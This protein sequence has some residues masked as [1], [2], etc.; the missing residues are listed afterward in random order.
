MGR[1]NCSECDHLVSDTASACPSCG[2][3]T[4]VGTRRRNG[5]VHVGSGILVVIVANALSNILGAVGSP[6]LLLLVVLGSIEAVLGLRAAL[7]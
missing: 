2:G 5:L 7:R 3:R 6:V 1:T 4:E